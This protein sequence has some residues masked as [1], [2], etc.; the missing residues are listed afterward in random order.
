MEEDKK[1]E[2]GIEAAPD[3]GKITYDETTGMSNRPDK[4]KMYK[5]WFEQAKNNAI[6]AGFVKSSLISLDEI[7]GIKKQEKTN[8]KTTKKTNKK[9]KQ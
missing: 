7:K 5:N 6:E 3:S 4:R 9:R 8:K 1:P 2:R